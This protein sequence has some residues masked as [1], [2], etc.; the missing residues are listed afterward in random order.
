MV[1][2]E[3]NQVSTNSDPVAA[4]PKASDSTPAK[5]EEKSSPAPSTP[6]A[7]A[8]A[9]AS[10]PP[11]PIASTPATPAPAAEKKK[12]EPE[13]SEQSAKSLEIEQPESDDDDEPATPPAPTPATPGAPSKVG[14]VDVVDAVK[15]SSDLPKAEA[16]KTGQ[17]SSKGSGS[18]GE[19]PVVSH[20][21]H[22]S[23]FL[24][25]PLMESLYLN[26]NA[27]AR[28]ILSSPHMSLEC[29]SAKLMQTAQPKDKL[30][31]KK[32]SP[33]ATTPTRGSA[34][35]AGYDLYS[36]EDKTVP[37]RGKAL[38]STDLSV[39]VPEGTYGRVAP[40]SGL[41]ECSARTYLLVLQALQPLCRPPCASGHMLWH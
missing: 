11:T 8:S 3:T 40:R 5:T 2:L 25:H 12:E 34:L 30:L 22:L 20:H 39:A 29:N 16:V 6:A 18:G 13:E 33:K 21:N 10:A 38:V 31:I 24:F 41:G 7:A 26:S 36:A 9:A 35:S 23:L 17:D 19:V 32:L 15:P 28:H 4:P 27:L 14:S 1:D 37:K